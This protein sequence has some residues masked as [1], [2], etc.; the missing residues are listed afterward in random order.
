[1]GKKLTL[2]EAAEKVRRS[3]KTVYTWTSRKLIP[4]EKVLG[5]VLFDEAEL[6]AWMAS[7]RVEVIQDDG[8]S[9]H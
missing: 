9:R 7:F 2:V 6:E 8:E 1:M 4:H 3:P 5:R